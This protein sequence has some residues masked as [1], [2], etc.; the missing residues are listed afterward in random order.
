MLSNCVLVVELMFLFFLP[1]ESLQLYLF[2]LGKLH[3]KNCLTFYL[4]VKII[5][6]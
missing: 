5:Y 1:D 6:L 3:R 2:V 4:I